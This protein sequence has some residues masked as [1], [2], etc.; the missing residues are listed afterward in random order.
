[1]HPTTAQKILL[2]GIPEDRVEGVLSRLKQAGALLRQSGTS[3]QPRVCIGKPYCKLALG[4]TFS[5]ARAIY[6]RFLGYPVPHKFKVAVAGCP[7]CCSPANMVDLGFIAERSGYKVLVGGK[8]GYKPQPGRLLGKATSLEEALL[9]M[10]AVLTF[11]NRFGEPKKRL[12]TV[13]EQVGFSA[14]EEIVRA[15]IP[16][17]KF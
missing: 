9:F 11:F 14:L 12:G 6:H 8:G 7:A 15:C 5:L 13:I 4:E 2:L 17:S 3:F 16:K 1:V 10:E